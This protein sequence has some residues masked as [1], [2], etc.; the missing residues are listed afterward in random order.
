MKAEK[1]MGK[2]YYPSG[3]LDSI[4]IDEVSDEKFGQGC[5]GTLAADQESENK[6][7]GSLACSQ[8]QGRVWLGE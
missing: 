5:T 3:F 8:K 4:E 6:L 2:R 7:T 1:L